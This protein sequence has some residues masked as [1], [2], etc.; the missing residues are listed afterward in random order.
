MTFGYRAG[1]AGTLAAARRARIPTF[2]APVRADH[3]AQQAALVA[4]GLSVELPDA[5][6]AT[7]RSLEAGL[8]QLATRFSRWHAIPDE[9]DVDYVAVAAFLGRHTASGVSLDGGGGW[10]AERSASAAPWPAPAFF[11]C[12][13]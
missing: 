9:A 10:G 1:G 4:A 11:F 8:A 6:A 13:D 12:G 3:R 2:V 7:P 5:A